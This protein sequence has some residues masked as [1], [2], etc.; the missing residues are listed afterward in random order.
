M[1]IIPSSDMKLMSRPPKFSIGRIG[2]SGYPRQAMHLQKRVPVSRRRSGMGHFFGTPK[3][4]DSAQ[5]DPNFNINSLK[6]F[7]F[8]Q[9][10]S[11]PLF[12]HRLC[13]PMFV[14]DTS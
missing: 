4:L 12:R 7:D 2:V 13:I 3:R 6:L 1:V 5:K 11:V 8:N 9:L 10:T 14:D